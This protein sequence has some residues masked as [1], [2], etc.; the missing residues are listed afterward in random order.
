VIPER[1]RQTM[2]SVPL[3]G[4]RVI[5]RLETI[6]ITRLAD[7]RGRDPY[8]LMHEINFEAGRPVWH[9]PIAIIALQNLIDAAERAARAAFPSRSRSRSGC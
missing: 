3:C 1:E 6:G 4:P 7:L 5:R 8:D 2:L 9:P